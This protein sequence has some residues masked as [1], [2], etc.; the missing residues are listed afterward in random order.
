MI[1]DCINKGSVSGGM[2]CGGIVGRIYEDF[3]GTYNNNQNEGTVNG[4]TGSES[5]AIGTDLR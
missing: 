4:A 1:I 5:N 2:N 3:V